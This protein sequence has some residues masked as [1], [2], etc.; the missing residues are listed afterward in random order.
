MH[1]IGPFFIRQLILLIFFLHRGVSNTASYH[2]SLFILRAAHVELVVNIF[3]IACSLYQCI[4]M[5]YSKPALS[6]WGLTMLQTFGG[7]K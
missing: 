1:R 7:A 2:V 4:V 5:P 3:N 6:D